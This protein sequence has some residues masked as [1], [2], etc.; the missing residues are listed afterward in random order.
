MSAAAGAFVNPGRGFLQ[1]TGFVVDATGKVVVGV[2]PGG[3]I[4]RLEG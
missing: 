4:G 3:A 1:S 2:Y